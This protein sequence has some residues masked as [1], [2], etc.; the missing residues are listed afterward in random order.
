LHIILHSPEGKVTDPMDTLK[1]AFLAVSIETNAQQSELFP[2]LSTDL[3]LRVLQ[4]VEN[5]IMLFPE[6]ERNLIKEKILLPQNKKQRETAKSLNSQ[7][8]KSNL[9]E[10]I[11]NNEDDPLF[12]EK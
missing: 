8:S 10:W 2:Q 6:E 7:I 11:N 12:E 1:H 3:P 5:Y 4:L 9:Q